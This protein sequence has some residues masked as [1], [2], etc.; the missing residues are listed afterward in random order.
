MCRLLLLVVVS[1][2]FSSARPFTAAQPQTTTPATP[3]AADPV[4]LNLGR[5]TVV[6]AATP[7]LQERTAVKVLTEDGW[8]E[9]VGRR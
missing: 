7:G 2:G 5:A 6:T 4:L 8:F 9:L 1:L 3:S